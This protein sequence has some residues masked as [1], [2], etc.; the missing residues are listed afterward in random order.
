MS[1]EDR[2]WVNVGLDAETHQRVEAY[3]ER[4]RRDA[5]LEVSRAAVVR[6]LLRQ[7]LERVEMSDE[8]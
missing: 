3:R 2:D 4:L 7:A 5:G 8:R 1:E 6:S